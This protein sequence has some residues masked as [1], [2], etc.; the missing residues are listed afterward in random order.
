MAETVLLGTDQYVVRHWFTAER[1]IISLDGL[2][3]LVDRSRATM[4]WDLSPIPASP[5]EMTVLKSLVDAE[6]DTLTVTR[7]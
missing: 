3:V 7:D 2:D 5:D 6:P 1:A 4:A